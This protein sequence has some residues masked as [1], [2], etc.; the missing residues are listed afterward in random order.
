MSLRLYTPATGLHKWT[1]RNNKF[2]ACTVASVTRTP[3]LQLVY[4][5]MVLLRKEG[6]GQP[7]K[8]TALIGSLQSSFAEAM[9]GNLVTLILFTIIAFFIYYLILKGPSFVIEFCYLVLY[10]ART[11]VVNPM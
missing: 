3:S 4:L 7:E 8:N 10:A 11:P 9:F 6:E 2:F 1:S 5:L